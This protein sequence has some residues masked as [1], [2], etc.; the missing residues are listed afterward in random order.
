MSEQVLINTGIINPSD[1]SLCLE[2]TT[3]NDEKLVHTNLL[4][5]YLANVE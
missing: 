2:G 4:M 5:K 3:A 1:I